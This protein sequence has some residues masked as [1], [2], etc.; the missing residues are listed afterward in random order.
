MENEVDPVYSKLISFAKTA[1]TFSATVNTLLLPF[2]LSKNIET[3]ITVSI[4]KLTTL[5]CTYF[6]VLL[7]VLYET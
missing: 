6:S 3:V 1:Q 7:H 2:S 5:E 4:S